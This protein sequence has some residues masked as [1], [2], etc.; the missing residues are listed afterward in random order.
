MDKMKDRLLI[1][2]DLDRILSAN[3]LHN[4]N[5]ISTEAAATA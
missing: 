3:E 2:L 4:V 5:R 1:L